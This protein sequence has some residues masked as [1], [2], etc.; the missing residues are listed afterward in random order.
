MPNDTDTKARSAEI[1]IVI[2]YYRLIC[3]E[4]DNVTDAKS[5]ETSLVAKAAASGVHVK[6]LKQAHKIVKMGPRDGKT[7][8][9]AVILYANAI[10]GGMMQQEEMFAN[11]EEIP[12]AIL[13]DQRDWL[14]DREAEGAGYSAGK[15]GEPLDNNSHKPGSSQHDKWAR[16]WADGHEDFV[17][18]KGTEIKPKSGSRYPEDLEDDDQ[19]DVT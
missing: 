6:A 16:G 13:G 8:L 19:E 17:A 12:A 3:E 10:S 11:S 5:V 2:Q 7:F 18:G 9:D 1:E 4:H 15:T 14:L